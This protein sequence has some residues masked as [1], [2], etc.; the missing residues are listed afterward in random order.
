MYATAARLAPEDL[1]AIALKLYI[2]LLKAGYTSLAEFHYLHRQKGARDDTGV[3]AASLIVEAAN[4]AGIALTLLPVLYAAG[5]FGNA[6]LSPEQAL[7]SHNPPSFISLLKALTERVNHQKAARLGVAFHSLRA[8][9]LDALGEVLERL[10][11]L[12]AST[13]KHIHISEQRREV[14]E[15]KAALGAPPVEVL[16]ERVA[17]DEAWTLVHATH[18]S[19]AE[20]DEIAKR[21]A[22]VALCPTTE[23]NL[24]DGV[25]P[26]EAYLGR[27]GRFAVGSDSNVSLD[28][29]EELRLLEY[30]AR[31]ATRRRLIAATAEESH[32]GTALWT[33]AARD[34]A[35]A[36]GRRA[37]VLEVGAEA[38]LVV[39][40]DTAPQFAGRKPADILDTFLFGGVGAAVRDVMVA[41]RWVVRDR[42]HALDEEAA[43]AY[44]EILRRLYGRDKST[45]NPE[46]GE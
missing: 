4:E 35:A 39:L 33:A 41:G 43:R 8:V 34:G 10:D 27:G 9:P 2:D 12:P 46:R 17:V 19:E 14:E 28:P 16:M 38:D 26:F 18:A 3:A 24:G 40:D 37:G 22:I 44:R 21:R 15:A 25:F 13:P 5:G 23:A 45:I 31:L 11:F 42:R 20:L 29:A 7:F 6:P 36:C 1:K 30:T 32:T